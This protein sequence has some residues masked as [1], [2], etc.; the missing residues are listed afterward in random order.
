V[1]EDGYENVA[2]LPGFENLEGLTGNVLSD[3]FKM[4][5]FSI[6]RVALVVIH[7]ST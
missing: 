5:I 7:I 3:T 1:T 2:D 6:P 4:D